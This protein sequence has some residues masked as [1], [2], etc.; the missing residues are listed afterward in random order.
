MLGSD[1]PPAGAV[2]ELFAASAE[3]PA[4]C[5]DPE[6]SARAGT[7]PALECFDPD[8]APPVPTALPDLAATDLF[9]VAV[10]VADPV[11]LAPDCPGVDGLL[12][13]ELEFELAADDPVDG[14]A[15]A[16]P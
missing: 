5:V 10:A 15:Q 4:A 9:E 11:E 13:P 14:S 6:E 16:T 12:S 2:P 8:L 7:T 1:P 3:E